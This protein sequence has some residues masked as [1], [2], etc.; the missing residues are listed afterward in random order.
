MP[1]MEIPSGLLR[2]WMWYL[3]PGCRSRSTT[4]V[5][6]WTSLCPTAGEGAPA[7]GVWVLTVDWMEGSPGC[8]PPGFSVVLQGIPGELA[9][10]HCTS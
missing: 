10:Q 4:Q 5:L 6:A 1:S 7:L 9:G 8:C 2:T 3:T